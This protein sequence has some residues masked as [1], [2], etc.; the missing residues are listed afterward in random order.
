MQNKTIKLLCFGDLIGTPG[1]MLFQ[2]HAQQ[3]KEKYKA[4]GI[5]VNG[6]NSAPNGRGIT[7][8]IMTQLKEAGADLVTGG[9]HIWDQ[10]EVYHYLADHSDLLRPAN[11][12]GGCPGRGVGFFECAGVKIGVI[13]LQ[14]RI[15]MRQQLDCPFRALDSLVTFVKSQTPVVIVDFHAE[16]SSEKAGMGLYADGRVSAVLGTHTHIQ[17]ADERILPGKT[18]FISDLGYAGSLNS[19]IGMTKESVLPNFLTQMPSKFEVEAKPPFVI[20]GVC[21][22]IEVSSGQAVSI[23]RFRIVDQ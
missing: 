4:D 17:T 10:K 9:N 7:A 5:I 20:S 1:C 14:G 11:F 8:K 2:K 3:L 6:E 23:E 18:A 19:M 22:E 16:A 12:P 15:Y 21:V 13:N